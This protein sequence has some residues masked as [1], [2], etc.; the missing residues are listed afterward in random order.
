MMTEKNK[1]LGEVLF[2]NGL[3]TREILTEIIGLPNS[4]ERDLGEV[5]VSK[6]ICSHD[7][8]QEAVAEQFGYEFKKHLDFKDKEGIFNSLPVTF[9]KSSKIVPFK[10]T[11]DYIEIAVSNILD[12]HPIDDLKRI[13]NQYKIKI[14]ISS[15][16][17]IFRIIANHFE[18]IDPETTDEII[19]DLEESDFEILSETAMETQDILDMANEA[20]IIRLINT[21][22]RQAVHDRASDI[23]FEVYEKELVVRF[24]VD[25]I[26]YK[27]FTPPK[28]YQDAIISRL[29]IMS[30]LNIAENRLP[31]DGRIEIKVG[32]K[33]IDIRVSVFPT[34]YGERIVLRLL[35]KSSAEL[36]LATL[37]FSKKTFEIYNEL[38]NMPHG[39]ILVTG[40]TGSG[41]STTLYSALT[42]LND[43]KVNIL[44]VEDPIEY[45]ILGI[46]QMQIK[47]KIGLTFASGLRSILRQDPDIIMIG[48][49]R[50]YETAEI[51]IQSALTGHRVFS[52]LHTNDA[53]SGITRLMDMGVEPFL[54]NS[55]VNAFLAQRLVRKICTKCRES[56]NPTENDFRRIGIPK[57]AGKKIKFYRGK[58]CSAC[59]NTG[60]SGRIGIFELLPISD[61]IRELIMKGSD[62]TVIKEQAM[63]EGM[64][65]L[66][67]D[68]FEKVKEGLTTIDEILRVS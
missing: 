33:E 8:I 1:L 20:P 61:K 39:I 44:T 24:R 57:A 38:I 4:S 12:V 31:Q 28:R 15:E 29:K 45:Q 7:D 43:E 47:P 11:R 53:A 3:I 59:L 64:K 65:T 58:G 41:K 48:E 54:I 23:H 25:G 16:T 5:L 9:L 55:S 42:T 51:A 46:G 36:D 27:M 21:I 13:F 49:I 6:G 67:E 40:P 32:G 22:I 2:K 66:L 63:K 34:Y 18:N 30:N 17:E 68:G 19:E 62:S 10:A 60:Y 50:D 14:S 52:T 26:L 37:G 56:Y 35:D